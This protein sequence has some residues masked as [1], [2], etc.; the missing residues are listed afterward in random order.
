MTPSFV[1]HTVAIRLI[2]QDRFFHQRFSINDGCAAALQVGENKISVNN[3]PSSG[4]LAVMEMAFLHEPLQPAADDAYELA[5]QAFVGI[6]APVPEMIIFKGSTMWKTIFAIAFGAMLG[7]LFRWFLGLK[8]NSLFPTIPPGTIIANMIGAFVIGAAIAYF[9]QA[10][11]IAPEWR[12]FIMT[13]FCGGLTTFSTFSAEVV[14]LLQQ[15]RLSW[16]F[17]SVLIHV[18]GSLAMTFA[19]ILTLNWFVYP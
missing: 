1:N 4:I 10:P 6:V 13:G 17:G 8:L 16:A 15:G 18:L 7:A 19:G 9:A 2:A 14:T 5:G 12:L 3:R 11:G